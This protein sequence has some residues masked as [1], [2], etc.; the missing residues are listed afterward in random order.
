[1]KHI[2]LDYAAATP[3]DSKV[4]SAMQPYF[5]ETFF[6]PSATY[7]RARSVAKDVLSARH[8]IAQSLG[9]RTSEIIFTAGG[10]EANNL[11]VHGVMRHY[12]GKHM[13]LGATEHSS[14]IEPAK[15][16]D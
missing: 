10:S 4:L 5:S 1:M 11:A 2:Y 13:V 7:L 9:V 14:I 12:P 15:A 16:Y 6:N 3:I 8:E